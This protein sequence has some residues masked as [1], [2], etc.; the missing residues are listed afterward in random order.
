MT[1]LFE[2]FRSCEN[3]G[4]GVIGNSYL[5]EE[6]QGNKHVVCY[7]CLFVV[8]NPTGDWAL[9]DFA[10]LCRK[11]IELKTI[12]FCLLFIVFNEQKK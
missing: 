5:S 4:I 12:A 10:N 9:T 7:A 1:I 3:I 11:F 2:T 6:A 8:I